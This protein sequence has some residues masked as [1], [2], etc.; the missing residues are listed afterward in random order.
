MGVDFQHMSDPVFT[1]YELEQRYL[2]HH[3]LGTLL[4]DG[5]VITPPRSNERRRA[6]ATIIVY[7]VP[8]LSG[9]ETEFPKVPLKFIP[10]AGTALMFSNINE[11]GMADENMIHMALPPRSDGQEK[12]I[13]QMF[14]QEIAK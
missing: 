14:A 8:P 13:M 11:E 9:G 5:T 7:L 3:D 6:F 1:K 10:E 4:P 12:I 2:T